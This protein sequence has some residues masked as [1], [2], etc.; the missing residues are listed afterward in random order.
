MNRKTL[1]YL[2]KIKF[3]LR[4]LTIIYF[5]I[6]IIFFPFIITGLLKNPNLEGFLFLIIIPLIVIFI[7]L[8]ISFFIEKRDKKRWIILL[9]LGILF[10][11]NFP[12]GTILGVIILNYLNKKEIK[13]YFRINENSNKTTFKTNKS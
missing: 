4:V 6:F 11:V 2:H 7:P 13:D 12:I 8:T 3:W 5:V 10:L 1:D 9:I